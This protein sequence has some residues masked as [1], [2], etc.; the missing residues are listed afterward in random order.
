MFGCVLN[1]S[2]VNIT[3]KILEDPKKSEIQKYSYKNIYKNT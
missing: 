2:L 3:S 1:M